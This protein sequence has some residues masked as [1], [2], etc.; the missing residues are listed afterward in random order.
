MEKVLNEKV[1]IVFYKWAILGLF[2]FIFV[3]SI[4]LTV[5][6]Q[7]KMFLMNG[8]EPRTSEIGSDHSTN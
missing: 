6:V 5:N 7:S 4:K 3:F 8:F 1:P 2:F